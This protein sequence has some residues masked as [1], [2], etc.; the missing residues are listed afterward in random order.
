VT[1]SAS[2]WGAAL[3]AFE[4]TGTGPPPPPKP[5]IITYPDPARAATWAAL[6][7]RH[8]R[9]RSAAAAHEP[10]LPG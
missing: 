7:E 9:A 5:E 1:G 6:W 2:A 10:G 8:E 4:A 3:L